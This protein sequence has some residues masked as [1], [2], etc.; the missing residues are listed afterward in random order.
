MSLPPERKVLHGRTFDKHYEPTEFGPV[1]GPYRS[2]RH[3]TDWI[4]VGILLVT[5]TVLFFGDK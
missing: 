1:Q 4:L 2:P 3:S 5:L